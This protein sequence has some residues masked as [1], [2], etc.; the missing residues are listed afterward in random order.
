MRGE[1]ITTDTG[2][3]GYCPTE[4]VTL[5]LASPS[6]NGQFAVAAKIFARFNAEDVFLHR[7]QTGGA[8]QGVGLRRVEQDQLTVALRTCTSPQTLRYLPR[9][10]SGAG[11]KERLGLGV[12]A[13]ARAGVTHLNALST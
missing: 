1:P 8:D 7:Q 5:P 12:A 9:C 13:L 10:T 3:V 2:K 6:E 4:R 11:G